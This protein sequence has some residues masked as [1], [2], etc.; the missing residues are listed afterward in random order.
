MSA[1]VI[2]RSGPIISMMQG[3][4]G[5]GDASDGICKAI[6]VEAHVAR[7]IARMDM[8]RGAGAA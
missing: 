6:V 8:N 3:D 7:I 5:V 1:P 4:H 2:R